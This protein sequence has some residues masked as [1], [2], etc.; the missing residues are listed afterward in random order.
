MLHHSQG[1]YVLLKDT[2]AFFVL[3]IHKSLVSSYSLD[4]PKKGKDDLL[5]EHGHIKETH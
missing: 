1:S 5:I 3:C 4:K 2:E